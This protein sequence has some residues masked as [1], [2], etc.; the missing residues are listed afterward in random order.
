MSCSF[1]K[2][3]LAFRC[4]CYRPCANEK[5]RNRKF[6]GAILVCWF[7]NKLLMLPQP[8][9]KQRQQSA[10]MY[11]GY[12]GRPRSLMQQYN[13]GYGHKIL[14]R[15]DNPTINISRMVSCKWHCGRIVWF[16]STHTN[17]LLGVYCPLDL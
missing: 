3:E 15:Q 8:S 1:L 14:T 10:P 2:V 11:S 13:S 16:D 5:T 9:T 6:C 12:G 17:A 4:R 7:R